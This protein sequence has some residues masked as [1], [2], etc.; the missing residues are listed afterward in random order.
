MIAS[1]VSENVKDDASPVSKSVKDDASP[2]FE[3]AKDD[4]SPVFKTR[5]PCEP[6]FWGEKNFFGVEIVG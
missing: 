5:K 1:P 3:N 6:S 4:V 2:V